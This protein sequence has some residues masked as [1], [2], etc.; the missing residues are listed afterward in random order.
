RRLDGSDR[1]L[2]EHWFR[3]RTTQGWQVVSVPDA[4]NAH[5]SSVDGFFGGRAWYR[6]DFRP[7]PVRRQSAWIVRFESVNLRARVWLNGRELGRHVG[8]FEPFEFRL[9]GSRP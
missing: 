4:W 9:T 3:Q 5:D 7:P 1:G 6:K 8:A 2:R